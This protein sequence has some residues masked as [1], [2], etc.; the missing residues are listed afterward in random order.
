MSKNKLHDSICNL[1]GGLL[2]HKHK[3]RGGEAL[4]SFRTKRPDCWRSSSLKRTVG[5]VDLIWESLTA[6]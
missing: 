3:F 6:R 2:F 4:C 5:Q 1:D